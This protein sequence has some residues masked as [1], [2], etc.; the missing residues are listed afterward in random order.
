M[1]LSSIIGGIHSSAITCE[2]A[3][4]GVP[5]VASCVIMVAISLDSM[6]SL[7]RISDKIVS[8]MS[9]PYFICD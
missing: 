2:L 6:K 8:I 3:S 5:G 7:V 4:V 1:I 9:V